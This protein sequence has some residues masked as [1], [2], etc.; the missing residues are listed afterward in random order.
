MD[1]PLVSCVTPTYGRPHL[2]GESVKCFLDQDYPNK[3]MII[4]N[5]Q[6]GVSLKINDCPNGI[7][8][9]N[10]QQR[11]KSLGA[12]RNELKNKAKG[13]YC[14]LWEDD[15]LSTFWRLTESVKYLEEHPNI[16]CVK[17]HISLMSTNNK[18][19]QICGNNFEGSTCYRMAFLK[20]HDYNENESVTMDIHLENQANCKAL[21]VTPGYWMIYRWGLN[22]HHLSGIKN[23]Q[24]SWE[25]SLTFQ[26]FND[27]KGEIIVKPEFQRDYWRDIED[28]WQ[29]ENK[30]KWKEKWATL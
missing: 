8:I 30:N 18:D 23:E 25:K 12:K 21:D 16:D 22:T 24:Q 14:C 10:Y 11:F 7:H 27:I 13:K 6:A 17:T 3:E 2:L 4:I 29:G 5:D 15:D 26:P 1:Y 28:F 20:E 9:W 19:Y